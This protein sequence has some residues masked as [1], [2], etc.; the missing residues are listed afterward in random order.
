MKPSSEIGE[1][2]GEDE[3][4]GGLD[5]AG[6]HGGFL[7]VCRNSVQDEID[8]VERWVSCLQSCPASEAIRPKVSPTK[9]LRI[10]GSSIFR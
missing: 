3:A 10:N 7:V 5:L 2:S 1:L 9:E 8:A 4:D 6:R